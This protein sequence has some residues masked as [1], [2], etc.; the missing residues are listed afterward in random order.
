MSGSTAG[1][2]A[3][4]RRAGKAEAGTGKRAEYGS[5]IGR[6]LA[7]QEGGVGQAGADPGDE[8]AKPRRRRKVSTAERYAARIRAEH[9]DAERHHDP[10]S[11]AVTGRTSG[12]RHAARLRGGGDSVA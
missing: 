8:P 6:L 2:I 10:G 4:Q 11:P 3:A 5:T 1:R 12:E 7:V 9:P